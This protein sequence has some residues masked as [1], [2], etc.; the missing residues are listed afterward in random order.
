MTNTEL[1]KRLTT[2]ETEVANLK[3][4]NKGS[5]K[6]HPL[7][8]LEKIH[9]TFPDDAAFREAMDI[10]RKF[11]NAQRPKTASKSKVKRK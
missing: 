3:V 2:L 8:T 11:R 6:R 7:Q 10:G 9:G 5:L 4:Q 1:E